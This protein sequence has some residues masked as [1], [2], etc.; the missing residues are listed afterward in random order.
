MTEVIPIP[1]LLARGVCRA[2]AQRGFATLTEFSLANGR[3]A[4]VIGLGRGGELVIVEI[5]SSVPDFRNDGKWPEYRDFCDR[6]YFAVPEEFPR[7]LIPGECGLIVADPFGAAILRE[8][9]GIALA[10]A[11][12]KAVTLRFALVGS[13]RLRRLLDPAA[14]EPASLF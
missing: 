11:R 9:P 5:K 14:E 10:P 13:D 1:I 6:F 2:L 8:S 12:R 3:R 4:D 7:D